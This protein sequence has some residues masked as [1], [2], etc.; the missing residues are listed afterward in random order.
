M[1]LTVTHEEPS[2]LISSASGS[3]AAIMIGF[4]VALTASLMNSTP[5]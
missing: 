5:P 1:N 3:F 4:S 2:F